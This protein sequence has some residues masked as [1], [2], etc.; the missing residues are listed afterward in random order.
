MSETASMRVHSVDALLMSTS[1]RPA[2]LELLRGAAEGWTAGDLA[3][4]LLGSY[5]EGTVSLPRHRGTARGATLD[6]RAVVKILR[7]TREQVLEELRGARWGAV[8]AFVL[9]LARED[10]IAKAADGLWV[11]IDKPRM[12]LKHRVLALLAADYLLCPSDYTRRFALCT[13]CDAVVFDAPA[14]QTGFCGAH[15]ISGFLEVAR[16]VAALTA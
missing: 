9:S 14:R 13:R 7:N 5:R 8:P 10:A 3:R 12:L 6:P 16:P 2:A 15:R 11:P 1:W 4:W